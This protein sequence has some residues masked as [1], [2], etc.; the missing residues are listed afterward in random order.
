VTPT[1][2]P[3]LTGL[4]QLDA[5]SRAAANTRT[6]KLDRRAYRIAADVFRGIPHAE[7]AEHDDDATATLAP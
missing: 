7:L 4:V 1:G 5:P 6:L 2:I 3:A